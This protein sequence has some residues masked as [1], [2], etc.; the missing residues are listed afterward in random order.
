MFE[1]AHGGPRGHDKGDERIE[2]TI[3]AKAP[4]GSGPHVGAHET[5]HKGHRQDGGDHGKSGKDGGV[6]PPRLRLRQRFLK[7]SVLVFREAKVADHVFHH[8]NGIIHQEYRWR[9]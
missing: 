6:P 2:K 4:T 5:A 8:H 9:R 1:K 7:T 3:A